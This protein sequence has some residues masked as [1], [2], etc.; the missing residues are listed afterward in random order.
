MMNLQSKPLTQVPG[1]VPFHFV[2]TKDYF[3][4]C[5]LDVE[6]AGLSAVECY[7]QS[8]VGS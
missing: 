8:A 7:R 2:R 6:R 1:A 5:G 3:A 4:T